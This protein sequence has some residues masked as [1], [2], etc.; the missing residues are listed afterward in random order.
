[1]ARTPDRILASLLIAAAVALLV[2]GLLFY[3]NV[4]GDQGTAGL[5]TTATPVDAGTKTTHPDP[6]VP[7]PSDLADLTPSPTPRRTHAAGR[8]VATRVVV[9][10]ENIDLPVVSRDRR[11]RNQGPDLYPPCDVAVYHTAFDQPG[12]PGTTYL[13][14]HA[15]DGMFLPLLDASERRNGRSLLRDLVQVYTSDDQMYVYEI[16]KVHRHATDFALVLDAPPRAQQL[17]LQTSEGPA[18]TIPK[19]QVLGKLV[20]VVPATKAEAHP[21]PHPRGCYGE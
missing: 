21:R 14:A 5:V 6:S 20:D 13:Y 3:V 4:N 12:Q 8:A 16:T 10:S 19:L 7:T 9:P 11:V 1:M 17:I 18:G 2:A 15:R